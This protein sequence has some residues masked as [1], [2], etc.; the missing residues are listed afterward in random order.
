MALL[1]RLSIYSQFGEE[2]LDEFVEVINRGRPEGYRPG[3]IDLTEYEV[4]LRTDAQILQTAWVQHFRSNGARTL[5][6]LALDTLED[7]EGCPDAPRVE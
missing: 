4:R 3:A 5:A 1:I 2:Q 7:A 6:R